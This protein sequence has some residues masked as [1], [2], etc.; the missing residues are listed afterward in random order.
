MR[1]WTLGV[2]VPEEERGVTYVSQLGLRDAQVKLDPVTSRGSKDGRVSVLPGP[3]P[4]WGGRGSSKTTP[5]SNAGQG[6]PQPASCPRAQW[7]GVAARVQRPLGRAGPEAGVHVPASYRL[8]GQP[9]PVSKDRTVHGADSVTAVTA[10][11]RRE[12]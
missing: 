7:H 9:T 2:G 12:T 3:R 11:P 8:R 1:C 4:L 5:D 6:R 10:P